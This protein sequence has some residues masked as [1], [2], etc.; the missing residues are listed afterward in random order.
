MSKFTDNYKEVTKEELINFVNSY[1]TKLH[2]DVYAIN[3]PPIGTYNDFTLNKMWPDTI[4]AQ[5]YM[6]WISELG[7]LDYDNHR[8]FWTYFIKVNTDDS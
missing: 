7:E 2:W 5:V 4:V 6:N 3:E 1:H 8:K